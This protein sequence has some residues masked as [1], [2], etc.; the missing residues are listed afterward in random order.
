MKVITEHE[1]RKDLQHQLDADKARHACGIDC[2]NDDE[3]KIHT[4]I[5][6]SNPAH[7][8]STVSRAVMRL[9]LVKLR[10]KDV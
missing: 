9:V 8:Q 5:H 10:R 7:M 6:S 3:K 2:F 1:N 4:F